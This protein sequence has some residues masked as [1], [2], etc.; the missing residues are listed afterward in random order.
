MA[1]LDPPVLP[2]YLYRYRPLTNK[3]L[4][5][6]IDV[7]RQQ[8]LWLSQYRA[9]NDPMEGFY[10]ASRRVR[11]DENYRQVTYDLLN[12]KRNIG[13]CSFSETKENELMWAH[14]A[15]N[16]AG[17]C[18]AY[19]PIALVA[20]LPEDTHLVRLAYGSVPPGVSGLEAADV[21][22]A[23]RKIL[24]HKKSS[25]VYEREWRVLG[26]PG[27]LNIVSNSCAKEVYLGSRIK[28]VHQQSI[29]DS[30]RD[31]NVRIYAMRVSNYSHEWTRL[32]N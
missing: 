25:W 11:A 31:R 23:A 16:Y 2:L 29:V 30:L 7:I 18:V 13:I 20:G 4:D 27:R 8:Y 3:T 17:I 6:E 14:Y 15:S 21:Q 1:Q 32:K 22:G 9:L 10:A 19:R 5:R 26:Q 12:A 24:S 28:P